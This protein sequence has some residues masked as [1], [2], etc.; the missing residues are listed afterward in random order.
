MDRR[1]LEQ[2]LD[3]LGGASVGVFGDLCLDGY[4]TL[5]Q[6][7]RE[8]SLE[9]GLVVNRVVG[10][11]FAPG[12]TANVAVNLKALGVGSVAAFGVVGDDALG[13]ELRRQL[14]EL[15]IDCSGIVTQD[16]SWDTTVFYKPHTGDE[17]SARFDV[18]TVNSISHD[19]ERALIANLRRAANRLDALIIGQQLPKGCLSDHT[20][21]ELDR[22]AAEDPGRPV[23]VDSRHSAGVFKNVILKING[24]E[25]ASLCGA[26]MDPDRPVPLGD[27]E[28]FAESIF[29]LTSRPVVITR[30]DRGLIVHD[31]RRPIEVPG[32]QTLGRVDP[33]GAGDTVAATIAALLAVGAPPSEAARVANIAAWVTV[34]KL[35]QTGTASAAEIL[36]AD[37]DYVVRPELADDVGR[38]KYLLG[39][40][41]EVISTDLDRGRIA[42]ALFDHDG[43]ISTLRQGWEEVMEPVMIRAILGDRHEA[44]TDRERRAVTD[45]VRDYIDR[46]AGIQTIRQMQALADMVR[47]F[48]FVPERRVLDA[49]G[50]KELYNEA[51]M[52]IVSERIERVRRSELDTGDWTVKGAVPFLREL[53]RRG[54][55]LYLASGTDE[56]DVRNEAEVLGYAELFEGRI[57]GAVGDVAR[58]SKKMVIDRIVREH[59]LSGPELVTFGDGPV[60]LRET[61]KRDGIAVGVASDEIRRFGPDITKRSRLIR[62]GADLVVPDFS[63]G[64]KLLE[65]LL[66][67]GLPEE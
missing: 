6:D 46:S 16:Q 17:E 50:Y 41:I 67:G 9:T 45:R 40:G 13:F 64:Q 25:A 55:R 63:Q 39:T 19:T 26:E 11:R 51:L 44:A 28:G 20:L 3:R 14:D 8:R 18:G 54:I 53:H 5:D 47:E 34:Q 22:L 29:K 42:H 43:T 36:A 24:A 1:Q 33:V 35:R 57:F 10:Q 60:E 62:A 61:V 2:L 31:G 12:G 58:Y 56:H 30:G 52:Q 27:L 65:H 15:G 48:G 59:D 66:S 38:A 32:I 23:L 37:P 4:W 7:H 49:A 21:T